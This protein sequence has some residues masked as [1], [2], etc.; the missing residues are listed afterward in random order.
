[1]TTTRS[2]SRFILLVGLLTCFCSAGTSAAI[3]PRYHVT[4]LGTLGGGYS[5]ALAINASGQVTGLAQPAAGF[6]N[7]FLWTPT[8]P[9]GTSGTIHDLGRLGGQFSVGR[10]IN[11]GGQV[12]GWSNT[13]G[14]PGG[15]FL[16]TPTT[17]GGASGT[18]LSLG[19]LGGGY[20][21]ARGI[22]VGGQITGYSSLA[23]E[24]ILPTIDHAFLW[25]PTTPGGASGTMLDLGTLG[26]QYSI[27]NGINDNGQVTGISATTGDAEAHAMLWT[28]TTPGGT[29]GT[30]VDLG[31]LA[32]AESEAFA[33]NSS[34]QVTGYSSTAN[35]GAFHAF[36]WTPT[37]PGG[38]TGSMLDLGTLA[39]ASDSSIG[40]GINSS[41]HVVGQSE[42]VVNDISR[43][44]AFMYTRGRGMVDLNAL[45][46]PQSGWELQD[47]FGINDAGQIVG[48]GNLGAYLL[49]P[50]PERYQIAGGQFQFDN[51]ESWVIA[52]GEM[53]IQ[54]FDILVSE[55]GNQRAVFGVTSFSLAAV[56]QLGASHTITAIPDGLP[57]PAFHDPSLPDTVLDIGLV[58]VYPDGGLDMLVYD[59]SIDG[60]PV[61][62]FD[63]IGGPSFVGSAWL[64]S[65]PMPTSF[66]VSMLAD[67]R[68][69]N[70]HGNVTLVAA[71]VPEPTSAVLLALAALGLVMTVPRRERT[72]PRTH[73]VL[74][75]ASIVLLAA[76]GPASAAMYSAA[77]VPEL[78]AAIN[79]ANQNAEPDT[80]ALAAAATF[81]LSDVYGLMGSTGLPTIAANE[82]LTILGNGSIIERSA[83]AET[84]TFRLFD[85]AA[86]A[87]L[88]LENMTL[89]RG[90]VV[91][92]GVFASGGA[93][94]NLGALSLQDVVVQ[95]NLAEGRSVGGPF[96]PRPAG[97]RAY[98]GAIY[99][100]GS[101]VFVG[102]TVQNNQAIGQNGLNSA[103]DRGGG[104]I[105]ATPGGAAFGGALFIN[106]GT[107]DLRDVLFVDNAAIGGKGGNGHPTRGPYGGANGADG[108]GGA[109]YH[110][111]GEITLTDVALSSNAVWGGAGGNGGNGAS[112]GNGGNGGAGFGGGL[113]AGGGT[114]EVHNSSAIGN[115]AQGGA[116]GSKGS[117]SG[118]TNGA[119]G[120]GRGGGLHL[121][122]AD[123]GLNEFTANHVYDNTASTSHPNIF[124]SYEVIPDQTSLL[125]DYNNN[126]T[127]DAAD[128]TVWRD[129]LGSTYTMADYDVWKSH[130]GQSLGSGAIG[131]AS[132]LP[133][134]PEPT[135]LALLLS[136]TGLIIPVRHRR[137]V[138][139]LRPLTSAG[140][141][142]LRPT[143]VPP[144]SSHSRE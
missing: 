136:I 4:D 80:I 135:S 124:G 92:A 19:M 60:E 1:M 86:D 51:G 102:G 44:H 76:D 16:W 129:G 109:I 84:P 134:I 9:N 46:D 122:D 63:T 66:S 55:E 142:G 123:V 35:F 95:D 107:Y 131:S 32:G 115:S 82:T 43:S 47:A 8:T 113:Y 52:H 79:A 41:G 133:A 38:T 105:P 29:I 125:G 120:D 81:T 39:G 27:G 101:L 28:P 121:I 97:E 77:S 73:R 139:K 93:I 21:E 48:V 119:I 88:H 54:F 37:T 106:E 42:V 61:D 110:S 13:D 127:V 67:F 96:N 68:S 45:I 59:L 89:Q 114:V 23:G 7:A 144:R 24:E 57:S 85:V 69:Q 6:T 30:M 90:R 116:G 128:Y 126:G 10:S 58:N 99:S 33:I 104:T 130:F 15:A 111:S 62:P 118:A 31:T 40:H 141:G 108:Y 112:S 71:L 117:S 56:D 100:L 36:V 138:P 50:V 14:E 18:M 53:S 22:N 103:S 34:G 3:L 74:V 20:S 70:L 2:C 87:S 17:P 64:G 25:T 65:F 98:G 5:D 91:G 12:A 137:A 140:S 75:A 11:A 72:P 78:I 26:G 83:A 49:T 132:A 94:F 143:P